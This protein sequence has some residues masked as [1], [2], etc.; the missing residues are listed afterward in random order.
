MYFKDSVF[1]VGGA[2]YCRCSREWAE[3]ER[4]QRIK[5]Q[6]EGGKHEERERK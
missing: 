3:Q 1:S 4:S 2:H 5:I 6:R